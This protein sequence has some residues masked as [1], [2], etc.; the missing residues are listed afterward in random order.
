VLTS[1]GLGLL[2]AGLCLAATMWLTRATEL[3]VL[4]VPALTL[5]LVAWVW[6][7]VPFK[8]DVRRSVEPAE[9]VR[10]EPCLAVL[11]VANSSTRRGPRLDVVDRHGPDEVALAV[12]RLAAGATHQVE[13]DLPTMRR[14][15]FPL[16]PLTAR[17]SDAF[18]LAEVTAELGGQASYSVRPRF[19][20]LETL[21]GGARASLDGT[22]R[23]PL[24]GGDDF[25]GLRD[26]VVGDDPRRIH[27][28]STARTGTAQVRVYQDSSVPTLTVVLDNRASRYRGDLFEDAVEVAASVLDLADRHGLGL[29]ITPTSGR[30]AGIAGVSGTAGTAGEPLDRAELLDVLTRV[31]PTTDPGVNLYDPRLAAS[32]ATLIVITGDL[33]GDDTADLV[34]LRAAVARLTLCVVT[35]DTDLAGLAGLAASPAGIDLVTVSRASELPD[36]WEA[37]L[38]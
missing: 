38:G 16:G 26:Y 2:P 3:L 10:G 5:P 6:S 12:P 7:R 22:V 27:W 21:P 14:G 1:R 29:V 28:L 17:R 31:T 25:H 23:R 37:A 35:P 9:V 13:T 34:R 36:C 32:S 15:V 20:R 11:T 18:D 24:F 30:H 8:V 4:A 19:H 33:R